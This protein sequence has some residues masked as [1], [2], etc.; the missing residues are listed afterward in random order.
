MT[1]K[2]TYTT[3]PPE[4]V[5]DMSDKSER[6]RRGVTGRRSSCSGEQQLQRA[7]RAQ[8]RRQSKIFISLIVLKANA[9]AYSVLRS[10][11]RPVSS[12]SSS[13]CF[14]GFGLGGMAWAAAASFQASTR[15]AH[16][17]R[18]RSEVMPEAEQRQPRRPPQRR[19]FQLWMGARRDEEEA[20]SRET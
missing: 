2:M 3:T 19:P 20:R 13:S 1:K 18:E 10:S 7:E 12:T 15:C 17:Q 6:V 11:A 8:V 4:K 5:R 14:T 16:E 9:S